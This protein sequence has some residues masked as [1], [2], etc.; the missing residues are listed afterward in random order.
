[1]SEQVVAELLRSM[2]EPLHPDLVP[3]LE[4]GAMGKQLRHPLVYLVPMWDSGRANAYYAQKMKDSMDALANRQYSKL[5]V[6]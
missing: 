6:S 3:Y 1:M 2:N 5:V 4:D